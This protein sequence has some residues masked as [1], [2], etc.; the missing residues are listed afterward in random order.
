MATLRDR[1]PVHGLERRRLGPADVVA[2]SIAGSAPSAAM[3]ATPVIV[4][5][6]AGPWTV[7]SFVAAA[8]IALLVAA[9]IGRFTTRMA[10]PGG[11]YPLTAQGLGSGP[12]FA[13]GVAAALGYLLLCAAALGGAVLYLQ[14]L[15]GAGPAQTRWG[16][17][18]AAVLC[19]LIVT[20]L[21]ARGVR[22]AARVVLLV[23]AI[24]VGALVGVFALLLAG[25]PLPGPGAGPQPAIGAAGLV[26]GVV[27]ALAAFIGFEVATSLGAETR[28]PFRTVPRAVFAT[29][30]VTGVLYVFAAAVQTSGFAAVPGGL[31]GQVQPVQVLATT[32]G[33]WWIPPVLHAALVLS[34]LACAV[35]TATALSRVLF[36]LARDGA[37]PGVLGRTHRRF[38]TP[39]VAVLAA[40]PTA[41]AAVAVPLAAGVPPEVLLVGLLGAATVGF[42]VTYL[43]VCLAAPLF[44]RRIGELTPA[45]VA[46]AAL[47]VPALFAAL[48]AFV[49]AAPLSGLVLAVALPAGAGWSVLQRRRGDLPALGVYDETVASDVWHRVR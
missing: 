38:R 37:V 44:L 49:V 47:A 1:S 7:W 2:Q 19:G 9:S 29:A 25:G 22:P 35:A 39:H 18:A 32:R 13:G 30:A 5:G 41:A 34:F 23:E 15:L 10:A 17:T 6:L 42:L 43:L 14:P 21:V 33:W 46:T 4:A 24:A 28:R 16:T 11:L 27:P 20:A 8:V 36:S 40:V 48:V 26:A 3:A 45:A 31:G 12:A